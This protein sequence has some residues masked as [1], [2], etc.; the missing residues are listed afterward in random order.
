MRALINALY[1]RLAKLAGGVAV[2]RVGGFDGIIDPT[3]VVRIALQDAASVAAL[4]VTTAAIII[5]RP[6]KKTRRCPPAA[7]AWTTRISDL[8]LQNGDA[9]RRRMQLLYAG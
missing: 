9:G 1:D 4:L 7:A 3:K 5:E 2:M 6:E 8:R